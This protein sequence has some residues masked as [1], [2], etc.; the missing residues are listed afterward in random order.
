MEKQD[1][2]LLRKVVFFNTE[3]IKKKILT[4]SRK[5]IKIKKHEA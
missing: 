2:D 4:G 5:D 1:L 3:F